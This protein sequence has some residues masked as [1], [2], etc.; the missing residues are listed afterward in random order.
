MSLKAEILLKKYRDTVSLA[1][2][3]R[4]HQSI[5]LGPL[6]VNLMFGRTDGIISGRIVQIIGKPQHGKTTLALDILAQYLNQHPER[7]AMYL[8]FE[9]TFDDSYAHS[10]G[11]PL[12][13]LYVVRADYAE[14]GLQILEESIAGDLIQLAVLDSV[15]FALPKDEVDKDFSDR[16]KMASSAT[17]ITRF[18]QRVVPLLDNKDTTLVLINQYR[19]NFSTMSREEEIPFGG[20]ALQYASSVIIKTALVK[21]EEDRITVQATVRK[22]KVSGPFKKTE[23]YINFGRG[24]DHNTDVLALA[25]E[26]DIVVKKGSW[27]KYGEMS[28]QG[29]A[30]AVEIFPMD[31]IKNAVLENITSIPKRE[32]EDDDGLESA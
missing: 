10:C 15:P 32:D 2:V 28:V 26:L 24:I 19:K 16:P 20:M 13:R 5:S 23:F 12:E 1:T 6:S 8:D 21:T 9:R 17:I 30:S 14:I 27:Y 7:Y 31:E 11:I 3:P 25:E 4:P 18:C 22:S 29:A